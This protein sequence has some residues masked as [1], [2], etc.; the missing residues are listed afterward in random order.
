MA[1]PNITYWELRA[2]GSDNNS[3]GYD[4]NST[5]T[6]T[7]LTAIN[8]TTASPT[9]S[10]ATYNFVSGDVGKWLY[11]NSTGVWNP[12]WYLIT[13]ISGSSAVINASLGNFVHITNN[14][15]PSAVVG[16]ATTS[17]PTG[18]RWSIDHSQSSTAKA[19]MTDLVID[20]VTNTIISS[21]SYTFTKADV[22]NLIR[23][24]AGTNFTTG[25]YSIIG[26][27][28][29]KA[30][31]D[32]AVGTIGSTGGTGY[33]GGGM[34]TFYNFS[35]SVLYGHRFYAKNGT[36]YSNGSG[37]NGS[38]F[39]LIGYNSLRGDSPQ[40]ND[41]PLFRPTTN[42]ITIVNFATA[43]IAH[44]LLNIRIDGSGFTGCTGFAESNSRNGVVMDC[45]VSNCVT[46][47]NGINNMGTMNCEADT[48]TTG[49]AVTHPVYCVA[50]NCTYGFSRGFSGVISNCV[51]INCN[52]G[53]YIGNC[54]L[55]HCIAHNSSVNGV[56]CTTAGTG[57]FNCLI[58]NSGGYGFAD[59]GNTLIRN[60]FG[61][62]NTLGN[63]SGVTYGFTTLTASP[64]IDA[65][66]SD[67][68]LNNNPGG[69][70]LVKN[71][72]YPKSFPGVPALITYADA[73]AAQSI[74]SVSYLNPEISILVKAGTTSRTEFLYLNTTG[75]TFSSVGLSASYV[76]PGSARTAIT[77]VTQTTSGSWTSGGFVE[78]DSVTMP[79]LYRLDVP[80]A[81]F[82]SGVNSAAIE[83]FN[84]N[85]N[86]R[87][88]V[89][90]H[91]TQEMQL[92]LTQTIPNST[93]VGSVGEALNA[94][95][96]QG[97]GKWTFDGTNLN[98]YAADNVTILKT[99]TFNSVSNPTMRS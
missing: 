17:S 62:G 49:F 11:I 92:D 54:T 45:K 88:V 29:G 56:Y 30:T 20:S 37:A 1:I 7:N 86:D 48:C 99:L 79:G 72:V 65:T 68:R 22:G 74:D 75:L 66:S 67:L 47:F 26:V 55:N 82:A 96:A 81:V 87:F 16:C 38:R 40:G 50:K 28:A 6:E 2:D 34:L 32:S 14:T 60:S 15:G 80:N 13:S 10:S 39:A 53:F 57:L 78:V 61:F 43:G 27:N 69:G 89:T 90:Y 64:Y 44:D 35:G 52:Y 19:S 63:S 71:N 84:S 93:T 5:Y 76:R 97:F 91:F 73:S 41:R 4:P 9:V 77:L 3:G 12:G 46:G 31:L 94:M 8:A 95:R 51:T 21:P 58:T 42:N 36:Y 33:L 24:T 98:M 23:I 59:G 85:T 25:H 18:G 83:I 70:L